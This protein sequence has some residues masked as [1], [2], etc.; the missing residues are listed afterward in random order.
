MD[1]AYYVL[2][3]I[4]LDF[5]S[6]DLGHGASLSRTYVHLMAHPMLAFTHPERGKPSPGPWRQVAA[7]RNT[8]S[9][10]LFAELAVSPDDSDP[11]V[12]HS[13][14]SWIALLLRFMTNTVV[15][16][17]LSSSGNTKDLEEGKA[18]ARLLEPIPQLTEGATISVELAQ[19]IKQ[20]WYASF[21]LSHDDGLTFAVSSLYHSHRSPK[22]LGMV[23]V[24]AALERLFSAHT[25]E[26][27][28]R[29]CTN[30][31]AFIEPP[32]E[33]RYK[34]FKTLCKLYDDRSS[35]AHGS[36]MKDPNAYEESAAL[37]YAAILRIIE[38]NKIPGK[39][40]LERELLAPSTEE[41]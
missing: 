22:S 40:F 14:A 23:S 1:K 20:N 19:W 35:A 7:K 24:W 6:F 11:K 18:S 33:N 21:P 34:L 5:D 26:L 38:L 13:W 4:Q 32:G 15:T 31:A 10:D 16:I 39:D 17:T 29:V 9:V 36:P 25:A 30:I 3:G 27:K 28:Y 8:V 41:P 12:H 2:S 37:A